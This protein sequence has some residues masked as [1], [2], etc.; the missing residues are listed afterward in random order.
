MRGAGGR[1]AR[2]PA[3]PGRGRGLTGSQAPELRL[4]TAPDALS[5]QRFPG[6]CSSRHQLKP[7]GSEHGEPAINPPPHVLGSSSM[8]RK[9]E[10]LLG[11]P[12]LACEPSRA[13]RG[14][15]AAR[16]FMVV[17][18]GATGAASA[19]RGSGAW[20]ALPP[21]ANVVRAWVLLD[22]DPKRAAMSLALHP[23]G[24][25]LK[26][27]RTMGSV[28]MGPRGIRCDTLP[29]PHGSK[30]CIAHRPSQVTPITWGGL[31]GNI[32][33]CAGLGLV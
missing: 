27:S 22:T 16:G 7:L 4:D 9:S 10:L 24:I 18:A 6:R 14:M 21:P 31:V 23:M 20:F 13:A 15:K 33:S 32:V 3:G 12:G 28:A 19:S 25:Q 11:G 29:E 2:A 30:A 26:C 1:D 17:L 5:H 8:A